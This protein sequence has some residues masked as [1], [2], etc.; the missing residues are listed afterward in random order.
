MTRTLLM[1][2][3]TAAA[4]S[5]AP[6]QAA[7]IDLAGFTSRT[8]LLDRDGSV[9]FDAIFDFFDAGDAAGDIWVN[10]FLASDPLDATLDFAG[11]SEILVSA[12]AADVMPEI[13]QFLF[14]DG[15]AGYLV[16]VDVTGQGLDFTDPAAFIDAAARIRLEELGTAVIPVPAALPLLVGALAAMGAV[17]RRRPCLVGPARKQRST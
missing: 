4:L 7:P 13:V 11:L 8:T 17:G 3:L 9:F 16:T 1:A 15:A 2:M 5:A 12:R 14:E 6:A 10:S